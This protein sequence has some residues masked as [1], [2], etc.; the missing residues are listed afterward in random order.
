MSVQRASFKSIVIFSMQ[1]AKTQDFFTD[2]LGLKLLHSSESFAELTDTEGTFK[3]ML[4]EAPTI[5]HASH[6]F[7]PLLIFEV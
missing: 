3:F 5:A 2:I 1:L 4:R 7:S 6:G